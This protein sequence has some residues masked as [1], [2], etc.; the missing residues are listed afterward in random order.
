LVNRSRDVGTGHH[1]GVV[2]IA[3]PPPM[4]RNRS[5]ARPRSSRFAWSLPTS[6]HSRPAPPSC[7]PTSCGTGPSSR[8]TP[9]RGL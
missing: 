9:P 7:S 8:N 1:E 2:V 3:P 5:Q 6:T 4:V